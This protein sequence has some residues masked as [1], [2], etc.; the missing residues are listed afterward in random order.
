[1]ATYVSWMEVGGLVRL[2]Q[3][4]LALL[5]FLPGQFDDIYVK[6]AI[7]TRI[8]PVGTSQTDQKTS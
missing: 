3:A 2:P 7:Y 6:N 5:L 1:M 4:P 8:L